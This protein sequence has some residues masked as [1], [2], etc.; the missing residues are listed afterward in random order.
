VEQANSAGVNAPQQSVKGLSFKGILQVFYS[1]SAFFQQ[2]KDQ[3]KVL[4]PYIVLAILFAV[5]F[6]LIA[7]LLVQLQVESPEL[8]EQ[9]QGQP[10]TDQVRQLLKINVLVG[11]MLAFLLAPL[12]AGALAFLVGNF[13]MGHKARFKQLLSVVLYGE[14]IYAA[15]ALL[16][17]PLMLAKGSVLVSL[18]LG[19]LAASQG[20]TSVLYLAL[21][22]IDL[23]II[24]EIIVVGIGIAT[25]YGIPRNKGY[26]ISV[27]SVGMLSIL[28]V[29]VTA[30]GKVLF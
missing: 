29:L 12:L 3:P 9:L 20:P 2:L 4:V 21:S 22:K 23:F 28:H 7:D 1:P 25:V 6:F 13:F 14:I 19:V 15:G 10:V 18:S 11:A 24:W 5:S 27:L 30:I 8:Q 26:V 16:L 17:A